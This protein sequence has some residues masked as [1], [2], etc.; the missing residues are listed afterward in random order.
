[1]TLIGN[2]LRSYIRKVRL[3]QHNTRLYLLYL[4]ISGVAFGVYALLFNFYILGLGYDEA[5][6]GRLLSVNSTA[7]LIG[8]L[9]A[10]AVSDRLGRKRALLISGLVTAL[11][12]AGLVVWPSVPGLFVMSV[13]MGLAQS[14]GAVT[15]APFLMENSGE[16]ERTY[17]FSFSF[18]LQMLIGMVGFWLGG[19]LPG[20]L[21]STDAYTGVMVGVAA[22]AVFALAP[23]L[24]LRETKGMGTAVINPLS[25]LRYARRNPILLGKFITPLLLTALGAGLFVPF[26]NVF[27]RNQYHIDDAAI[28]CLFAAG[29]LTMGLGFLLAPPLADRYGK[30]RLVILTQVLFIPALVLLGFAPW[31][32]L[33]AA[34]YL[35]RVVLMTMDDPIY[36]AFVMESVEQEARATVASLLTM[37]SSLGW[38]VGPTIS[39]WLQVTYGFAPVFLIVVGLYVITVLLTWRFF[40]KQARSVQ[41][42]GSMPAS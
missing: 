4:I 6:L 13:F 42:S 41:F 20:W 24:F 14:L 32:W 39:G 31:F 33:S 9:P 16:E 11:A 15:L 12:I 22:T 35:V 37:A 19:R 7:A 1:M 34:A 36:Q 28:G 40:G 26:M 38:A 25:P 3:F 23:L 10:G 21:G 18:S 17:L 27:F 8:A 2:N 29:S 30:I 5:L